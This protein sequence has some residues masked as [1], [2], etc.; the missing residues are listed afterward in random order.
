M[1][2]WQNKHFRLT[3]LIALAG[4]GQTGMALADTTLNIDAVA[5]TFI[6]SDPDYANRD[7]SAFGAMQISADLPD[8]IQG[9]MSPR[10]LDLLVAYDTATIKA[11]FDSQY[12]AGNWHVTDV[13]VKW[14]TNFDIL[15][16]PAHNPQFNVP[17]AGDF[18]ISL[19]NDN[20]WFNAAT[21][22]PLGL[23]NNDLNWNSVFGAGGKY[24]TL[25]NG[26]QNLTS[27]SYTGGDFN[28]TNNCSND[29][30]APRFWDL[31][32]NADLLA[33]VADGGVVSL[34]G[35]AADANVT[36]LVNQLTKPGGH[37]QI[38]VSAAAGV[39][40]VPTPG[41]IWLFLS[42][43]LPMLAGLRKQSAAYGSL[44]STT[45]KFC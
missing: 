45:N 44:T 25:L 42:G 9:I 33:R 43:C 4:F 13:Q 3:A 15:G 16:V 7:M 12:G 36:Y 29:V 40:A 27:D 11:G 39:A 6:S 38:F 23:A 17:A 28:G 5:D 37:P 32:D 21:A 2:T 22:G 30:C 20:N 24:G 31:G 41:G 1:N 35:T 19:L 14:Y 18:N 10:T 34:F 8:Y 26:I